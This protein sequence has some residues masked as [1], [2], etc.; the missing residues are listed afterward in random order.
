MRW[1]KLFIIAVFCHI[2]VHTY[3]QK[4]WNEWFIVDCILLYL[5]LFIKSLCNSV[6]L[7]IKLEIIKKKTIKNLKTFQ[8]K[9]IVERYIVY[10]RQIS[11]Y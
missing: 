9:G 4:I 7:I 2:N 10:Y 6:Y 1:C 3:V 5:L 11:Y 8:T